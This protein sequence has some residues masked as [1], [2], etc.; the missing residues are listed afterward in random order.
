MCVCPR[1]PKSRAFAKVFLEL[2]QGTGVTCPVLIAKKCS[3]LEPDGEFPV[4]CYTAA[5]L[6]PF[7]RVLLSLVLSKPFCDQDMVLIIGQVLM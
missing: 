7:S 2:L 6:L 1:H 4:T 5:V 3:A